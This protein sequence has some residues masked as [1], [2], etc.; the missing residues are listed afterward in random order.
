MA[1]EAR[2]AQ[3]AKEPRECRV[4]VSQRESLNELRN[5]SVDK[6]HASARTEAAV[7]IR[8][9]HAAVP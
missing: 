8:H 4:I 1:Q 2:L 9:A 5:D 3:E 7:V 6:T